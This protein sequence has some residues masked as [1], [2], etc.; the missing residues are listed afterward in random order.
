MQGG[1]NDRG[2][3]EWRST[4]V[5]NITGNGAL[6]M[7]S[8]REGGSEVSPGPAFLQQV[9]WRSDAQKL[10]SLPGFEGDFEDWE[11]VDQVGDHDPYSEWDL[12]MLVVAHCW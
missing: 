9:E 3:G 5:G 11:R 1:S 8:K 12:Q 2:K 6:C 10:H 4:R 7:A